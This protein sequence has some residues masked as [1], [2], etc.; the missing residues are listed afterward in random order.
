M[1]GKGVF[2][3]NCAFAEKCIYMLGSK[4]VYYL[5]LQDEKN[6]SLKVYNLIN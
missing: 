6:S 3:K 4:K 1:N 5:N 2:L